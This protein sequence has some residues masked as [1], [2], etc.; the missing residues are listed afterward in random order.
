[1][2][3]NKSL[4]GGLL[5]VFLLLL[6]FAAPLSRMLQGLGGQEAQVSPLPT[7]ELGTGGSLGQGLIG[8]WHFNGSGSDSAGGNNATAGG[9]TTYSSSGLYSQAASF[10]GNGDYLNAGPISSLGGLSSFTVSAWV[11]PN[12]ANISGTPDAIIT[13]C[14]SGG[15]ANKNFVLEWSNDEVYDFRV[16]NNSSS[17]LARASAPARNTTWHHVAGVYDGSSVKLYLDGAL[18]QSVSLSGV[19]NSNGTP[20]YLGGDYGCGLGAWD[21]LM[22]EAAIWNRALSE[23]EIQSMVTTGAAPTDPNPNPNPT[24]TC[25]DGVINGNEQCD[26]SSLNNQ[27]CSTQGFTGG[28]LSCKSD[29][30]FNTTQCTSNTNPNPPTNSTVSITA[31]TAGSTL[32][33]AVAVQAVTSDDIVAVR[34]KVDG[35]N[36]GTEDPGRPFARNWDTTQATNGSHTLTAVARLANNQTVTSEPVTVTVNNTVIPP[37]PDTTAPTVSVTA[38]A[39]NA[40]VSGN[41]TLKANASDNVGVASVQFK[42]D[43]VVVGTDTSSPYTLSWNSTAVANGS[44]TVTAV[45]S[46]T[47]NPANTATAA[48][49]SFVVN[50]PVGGDSSALFIDGNLSADCTAGNYSVANRNCSGTDGNA[51]RTFGAVYS[52]VAPGSVVNIRSGSYNQQLAP[53]ISGTASAP[54][55]FKN[56]NN[57]TVTISGGSLNPGIRLANVDYNRF[58]G[59]KIDNVTGWMYIADSDRNI[60]SNMTFSNATA[61][62]TTGG[63]K[64]NRSHYNQILNSTFNVGN[65]NLSI[66]DSGNNLVQGNTFRSGRHSLARIQ[67]GDFNIIKNNS[68]SNTI[69]NSLEVLDC[70]GV[71]SDSPNQQDSTRYNVIEG[72]TFE[73]SGADEGIQFA[74]Q[75]TIVRRNMVYNS[76][77]GGLS[78]SAY[79]DNEASYNHDNR[80]YHN[81]FYKNH[82]GGVTTSNGSGLVSG[83][84][85]QNNIFLQNDGNYNGSG[86]TAQVVLQKLSGATT[87]HTF[88]KNNFFNLTAGESGIIVSTVSS[89]CATGTLACWQQNYSSL[90]SGN[91]NV[92]PGFEGAS[93]YDFDLVS[94]SQMIDAGGFLTTTSGSGSNSTTMVVA[95]AGYFSDGFGITTG[96]TIQLQGWS[97]SQRVQVTNVNYSTRT[98]TLAA[99]RSWS[100]G[101]GVALAYSGTAP[102]MGAKESGFSAPTGGGT[103]PVCGNGVIETGEMCDGNNLGGNT[104]PA[105][106]SGTVTCSSSCQ[107]NTTQCVTAP[108]GDTTAPTVSVTAPTAG[109]TVGGSS[110]PF[111][112]T[113]TDNVAVASVQ[114]RIDGINVGNPDTAAPYEVIWNTIGTPNNSTHV[115]SAVATDTSGNTKTS[116]NVSVIVSNVVASVCGNG[117][118][119]SGEQCDGT[120]L[121]GNTCP[122]G[123]SGTVTCSSSCQ[124]NTTQCVSNPV[125]P[126][127]NWTAPRGI[128]DPRAANQANFDFLQAGPATPSPWSENGTYNGQAYKFYYVQKGGSPACSDNNT[129]GTPTA[130]R[131]TIPSTIPAGSVVLV[132]GTYNNGSEIMINPQ[133]TAAKPVFVRSFNPSSRARLQ[134]KVRVG[135]TGTA[136]YA[137]FDNLIVESGGGSTGKFGFHGTNNHHLVLRNSDISGS[138]TEGGVV[139]V[140][141]NNIIYNNVVHDNGYS[142]NG[143]DNGGIFVGNDNSRNIWI[144]D[145]TCYKNGQACGLVNPGYYSD[146]SVGNQKIQYVYIGRNTA[147]NGQQSLFWSK[148][149]THIVFSENIGHDAVD[150]AQQDPPNCSGVQYAPSD[151]WFIFNTFYNC[152]AG[153]IIQSDSVDN[154]APPYT[155]VIANKIYNV[156]TGEPWQGA[157]SVHGSDSGVAGNYSTTPPANLDSILQQY[158]ATY[159]QSFGVHLTQ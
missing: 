127:G 98:L 158:D 109:S 34:F 143:Q 7:G 154:D 6:V 21:G 117:V 78:M 38:P 77:E 85:F 83:N 57:E 136:S 99:P 86:S 138:L 92:N 132:N 16:Y 76:V 20:V 9:N 25:G 112:V 104:C 88:I 71:P 96:D 87:G 159:F 146:A 56:Y 122:A 4:L 74:G 48:S 60:F 54:I 10:D 151:V 8:L 26:G 13:K 73:K 66:I 17:A 91:L 155:R 114:F 23:S 144:L 130:P 120:N 115:L 126:S 131:C 31:P 46:D 79:G 81:V 125:P 141:Q 11:K 12:S 111:R 67:C 156:P 105:G 106:T 107:L 47:A 147:Y 145:N 59:L 110:V 139:V 100:S 19:Q 124:L 50:N 142:A 148:H 82:L 123:T 113:A 101:T 94:G 1:M 35:N 41:F 153:V 68:F 119:E 93:S 97:A 29:C 61:Q 36:L 90:F 129:Y 152:E 18:Q 49:V 44:H 80:I 140:G 121:G 5:A 103:N 102:D 89:S 150:L 137:I 15:I 134:G 157:V 14:G 72:N 70:G 39:A 63:V 51:Y 135:L 53:T 24:A 64:L 133:G 30:T 37:T 65:D 62:G 42:V 2:K 69:E 149:G 27:S 45:A 3:Q 75:Y 58:E 116:A 128:P 52:S 33:G 84:I 22:D 43:G 32:N 95:D 55:T 28:T 40:T 108:A 118:I